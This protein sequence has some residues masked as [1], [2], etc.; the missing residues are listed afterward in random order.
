[1]GVKHKT[2]DLCCNLV[3]VYVMYNLDV[4][5]MCCFGANLTN[6]YCYFGFILIKMGHMATHF[7]LNKK[8]LI[9]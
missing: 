6:N 7:T 3:A 9:R 5:G 8:E 4:A 2:P 1:M